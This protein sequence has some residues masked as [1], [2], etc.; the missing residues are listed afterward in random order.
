MWTQTCCN[1]LNT[2]PQKSIQDISACFVILQN[3]SVKPS[4]Q[5]LLFNEQ[6][7]WHTVAI[8]RKEKHAEAGAG[9]QLQRDLCAVWEDR[10]CSEN[11]CTSYADRDRLKQNKT[12]PQLRVQGEVQRQSWW[13]NQRKEWACDIQ[14][15][16]SLQ[17]TSWPGGR[18]RRSLLV[19]A[20]TLW[21]NHPPVGSKCWMA[22]WTPPELCKWPVRSTVPVPRGLMKG[23]EHFPRTYPW[24]T[25]CTK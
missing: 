25:H 20:S 17:H 3:K 5:N 19:N 16:R 10:N 23:N 4:N 1:F 7:S 2:L 14:Q 11:C 9:P 21:T 18:F 24:A 13:D 8:L 6:Q 12:K 15:T 22:P